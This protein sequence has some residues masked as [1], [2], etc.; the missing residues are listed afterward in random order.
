MPYPRIPKQHRTGIK[1]PRDKYPD[2]RIMHKDG[3]SIYRI[4][5]E[6]GCSRILIYKILFPDKYPQVKTVYKKLTPEQIKVKN[7]K[8]T[9]KHLKLHPKEWRQYQRE[10]L[11]K[12]RAKNKQQK[13]LAK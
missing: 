3:V 8:I 13:P 1:V 9:K 7:K 5:K 6:M 2:V 4:A 11:Q 12:S 10:L